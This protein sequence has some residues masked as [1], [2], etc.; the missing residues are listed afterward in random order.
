MQKT[1]ALQRK[2]PEEASASSSTA[3]EDGALGGGCWKLL[4][5]AAGAAAGAPA[6]IRLGLGCKTL[7]DTIFSC[8]ADANALGA[9]TITQATVPAWRGIAICLYA[10][11]ENVKHEDN[12]CQR[13]V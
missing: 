7:V 13:I 12:G 11:A 8:T 5:A 2:A 10:I 4:E 9:T 1:A 3:A 6:S